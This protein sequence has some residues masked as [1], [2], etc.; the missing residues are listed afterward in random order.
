MELNLSHDTIKINE[1]FYDGTLEQSI[2]YEYQLPDYYPGIFK[3]LQC[4]IEPHICSC[5][6]STDQLVIDGDAVMKLMYI[7]EDGGSVSSIEQNIPF[8]KTLDLKD[9]P[10]NP[11]IFCSA[12]TNYANCR[13][14]SPRKIEV[15]GALT[16]FLKVQA[17]KEETILNDASGAGIEI[18]RNPVLVT[19]EQIWTTR[20]F[21]ISEQID[22][23]PP[24]EEI[25]D[26]R[27]KAVAEDCKIIANKAITK[28]TAYICI[29]YRTEGRKRPVTKKLTMPISQI[30]DMPGIDEEFECDIR[31][32]VTSVDSTTSQDGTLLNIDADIVVN[33]CGMLSCDID[34]IT[35]AYSTE[36]EIKTTTKEFNSPTMLSLI[37]DDLTLSETLE[38]SNI[39]DIYDIYSNFFDVASEKTRDGLHFNARL[40]I[41][42]LGSNEDE[43][44]LV[45]EKSIPVEFDITK[46]LNCDN[47]NVDADIIVTNNE[48]ELINDEVQ[49][50]V[51]L[52]IGGHISCNK[53]FLTVSDLVL[54]E[55]KPK[56][57]SNSALTLYY[58]EFGDSVWNIAKQFCTSPNA[59]MEANN[60][61]SNLVKD[62]VMLIIPIV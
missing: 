47:P 36:C 12:K 52:H 3:L 1:S 46:N 8:S 34:A 10:N 22:L 40:N 11:A 14:V 60:L 9:E 53:K 37:D 35:D 19:A 38:V 7:D 54:D 58:P 42:I 44:T 61:E 39:K 16:I 51:N 55:T 2:E 21:S 5:R 18:N 56:A 57:K 45:F 28:G 23:D 6:T 29:L 33:C 17:Q 59:I 25:L 31:Y 27:V 43:E 50:K 32:D 24:A 15:R 48:A 49:I 4:R 30:I 26:V 62:K 13:I 41:V 20:Q